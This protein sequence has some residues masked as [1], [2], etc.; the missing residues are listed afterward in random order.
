MRREKLKR[1]WD[2]LLKLYWVALLVAIVNFLWSAGTEQ[3]KPSPTVYYQAEQRTIVP[4]TTA[5]QNSSAELTDEAPNAETTLNTEEA[6]KTPNPETTPNTE[7]VSMTP[8]KEEASKTSKLPPIWTI[9]PDS[10][11][12]QGDAAAL[13]AL[14][15]VGPTIAER[16][17]EYREEH[18]Y[19]VYPEDLL[20]VKG[21]GQGKM[22]VIVEL[23]QAEE[24]ASEAKEE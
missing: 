20:G 16:I 22:T 13:D 15:G 8:K 12:N 1:V 11:V 10:V 14:P 4:D 23:L 7:E 24:E 18:G 17:I 9:P 3:Y 6:L 19:F 5:E 21:I 2:I